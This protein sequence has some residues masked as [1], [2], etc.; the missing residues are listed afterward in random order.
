MET[1]TRVN[2]QALQAH[3]RRRETVTLTDPRYPDV[4]FTIQLQEPD[5]M[6]DFEAAQISVEMIRR[7]ITGDPEKKTPPFPFLIDGREQKTTPQFWYTIGEVVALQPDP[8]DLDF[9][10]YS[11]DDLA[12]MAYKSRRTWLQ[13]W[14]K[15][16]ELIKGGAA[17]LP[18]D[19][20]DQPAAA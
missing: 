9:E 18:N 7:H 8:W 5:P 17:S 2:W 14:Q 20:T 13:L 16:R 19:S 10:R 4:A 1:A 6:T 3:E 12:Q 15:S 11:A